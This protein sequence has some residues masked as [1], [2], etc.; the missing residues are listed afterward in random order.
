MNGFDHYNTTND[1]YI[2]LC[3]GYGINS[4]N[5]LAKGFV[6]GGTLLYK[7][8]NYTTTKY[9][10][11]ARTSAIAISPFYGL[12]T[13]FR[14]SLVQV[15]DKDLNLISSIPSTSPG[16]T[17]QNFGGACCINYQGDSIVVCNN[18]IRVLGRN[19]VPKKEVTNSI[20]TTNGEYHFLTS[21][22]KKNIFAFVCYEPNMGREIHVGDLSTLEVKKKYSVTDTSS[23]GFFL[24]D[25]RLVYSSR[26]TASVTLVVKIYTFDF[27]TYDKLQERTLTLPSA[28]T[29]YVLGVNKNNELIIHD[30]TNLKMYAIN[31]DTEAVRILPGVVAS[32]YIMSDFDKNYLYGYNASTSN[33]YVLDAVTGSL[34]FQTSLA[35]NNASAPLQM[36]GK[37]PE[38]SSYH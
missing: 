7:D 16:G 4:I 14:N 12:I 19:G 22:S 34:L 18:K 13:G 30:R 5:K 15:F 23:N 6:C 26:V 37:M 31:V 24:K 11:D 1:D 10:A 8:T 2:L 33:I 3:H 35:N 36:R 32:S 9:N 21:N 38:C 29:G 28:F 20:V 25:G 27:T 17:G